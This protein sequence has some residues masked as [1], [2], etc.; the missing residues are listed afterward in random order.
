LAEVKAP[1]LLIVGGDDMPVI[2]LNRQ[3]FDRLRCEK[4]LE[5]V[6]G[7]THLFEEPGALETV[8][9][10]AAEWYQRHSG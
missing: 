4:Q 6:P 7:A 10:M 5:I 3:A 1:T 2:D 9:R 8:A